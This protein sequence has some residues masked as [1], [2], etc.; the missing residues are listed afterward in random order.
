VLQRDVLL[1]RP[2][3]PHPDLVEEVAIGVLGMARPG[4]VVILRP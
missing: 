1:L 2:D 3:R 4:D